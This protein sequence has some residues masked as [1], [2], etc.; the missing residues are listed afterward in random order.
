VQ[1]NATQAGQLLPRLARVRS[2]RCLKSCS[3][4]ANMCRASSLQC[5]SCL[6]GR[7]RMLAGTQAHYRGPGAW[8]VCFTGYDCSVP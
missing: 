3:M 5:Q 1:S 4:A 7:L 6:K 2:C 8:V